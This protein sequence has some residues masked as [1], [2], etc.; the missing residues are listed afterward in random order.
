LLLKTL[1]KFVYIL[2]SF[3]AQN[4]RTLFNR[5]DLE[6]RTVAMLILLVIRN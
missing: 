2:P 1:T 5:N 4:F 6:V 3:I